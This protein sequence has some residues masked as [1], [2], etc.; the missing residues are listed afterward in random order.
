MSRHFHRLASCE[1]ALELHDPCLF[2]RLTFFMPFRALVQESVAQH[3]AMV[4]QL[5]KSLHEEQQRASELRVALANERES[6]QNA[7]R[8]SMDGQPLSSIW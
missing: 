1:G 3:T 5:Q 6:L 8:V 2:A 7:L 4:A